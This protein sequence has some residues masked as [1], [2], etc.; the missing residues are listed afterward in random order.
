MYS[1]IV[2]LSLDHKNIDPGERPEEDLRNSK[3]I[4]DPKFRSYGK[5]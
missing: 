1:F 5:F 2:F 4:E 3:S